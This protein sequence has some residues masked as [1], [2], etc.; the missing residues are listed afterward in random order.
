[1]DGG[2]EGI[3]HENAQVFNNVCHLYV[4]ARTSSG[5]GWWKWRSPSN[6]D[7]VAF[8]VIVREVPI[9]GPSP[10]I[11]EGA[12]WAWWEHRDVIGEKQPCH[13]D[14]TWEVVDKQQE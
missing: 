12:L 6:R 2:G 14:Y 1:M 9:Y 7:V 10:D 8:C 3:V 11:V 4:I 13:M 5:K